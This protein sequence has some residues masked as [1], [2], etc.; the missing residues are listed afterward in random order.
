MKY[1]LYAFLLFLIFASTQASD[2]NLVVNPEDIRARVSEYLDQEEQKEQDAI[3]KAR[4]LRLSVL[5]QAVQGLGQD[6]IDRLK[7]RE[8]RLELDHKLCITKENASILKEL[9]IKSVKY[10]WN[11]CGFTHDIEYTFKEAG[12]GIDQDPKTVKKE[13]KSLKKVIDTI[14]NQEV[15]EKV[16]PSAPLFATLVAPVVHQFNFL[17]QSSSPR[18]VLKERLL[19]D[20]EK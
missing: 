8:I 9:F 5:L 13:A 1:K 10:Q 20:N 4:D 17:S 6:D 12:D 15:R 19:P 2:N 14:L 18:A 7:L 3:N 16:V 11:G